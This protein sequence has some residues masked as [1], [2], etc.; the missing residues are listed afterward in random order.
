MV[1]VAHITCD[2]TEMAVYI[3]GGYSSHAL[4][5]WGEWTRL[6]S[7]SSICHTSFRST[8]SVNIRPGLPRHSCE[9]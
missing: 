5:S 4:P 3:S 6:L 9:V 1:T 8:N 7:S 2:D